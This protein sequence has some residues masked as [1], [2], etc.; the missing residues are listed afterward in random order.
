M[1]GRPPGIPTIIERVQ[2]FMSNQTCVRT[3]VGVAESLRIKVGTANWC[4]IQLTKE[5]ILTRKRGCGVRGGWGYFYKGV[6]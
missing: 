1:K 3:V 6:K 2:S 4:L 5:G